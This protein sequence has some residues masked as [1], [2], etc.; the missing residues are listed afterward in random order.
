MS[1]TLTTAAIAAL[2][3]IVT[4]IMAVAAILIAKQN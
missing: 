4:M 1:M 2:T 3:V